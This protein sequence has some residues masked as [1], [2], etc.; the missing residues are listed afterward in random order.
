MRYREALEIM[1]TFTDE[2]L[3]CD[4]TIELEYADEC[5]PAEVRICGE[6]HM[7]LGDG[8]PV[9]FTAHA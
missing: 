7:M 3:N 5:Y 6:D 4:V 1:K 2:Q 8:H 9:I